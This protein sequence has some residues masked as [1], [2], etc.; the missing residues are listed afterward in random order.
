[1]SSLSPYQSQ[2]RLPNHSREFPWFPL[3]RPAGLG[4]RCYFGEWLTTACW[5]LRQN[6]TSLS[7]YTVCVWSLPSTV[8][9]SL[10]KFIESDKRKAQNHKDKS[11][12]TVADCSTKNPE[13][14]GQIYFE[15][16]KTTTNP[17]STPSKAICHN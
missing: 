11:I 16:S 13:G 7:L 6:K 2:K 17:Q 9:G 14:L 1:M 15:F 4:P 5:L 12:R 3:R 8:F 10:Q